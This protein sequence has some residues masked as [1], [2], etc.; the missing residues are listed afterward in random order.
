[1]KLLAVVLLV[2]GFG[3]GGAPPSKEARPV[4]GEEPLETASLPEEDV[5]P[6]EPEAAAPRAPASERPCGWAKAWSDPA[7]P[8]PLLAGIGGAPDP[9]RLAADPV[10]LPL[11]DPAP[12]GA[13]VV[14]VVILPDGTI[15]EATV[16]ATTDPPWPEGE[17]AVLDAVATWR[18][19]PPTLGGT[20]VAVCSNVVVRP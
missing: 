7:T 20:P 13:I 3:C 17:A 9:E 2:L 14:E 10:R 16:V 11:R 4:P 1:M 19:E 5:V 8:D 18:Y 15:G 6:L 12:R